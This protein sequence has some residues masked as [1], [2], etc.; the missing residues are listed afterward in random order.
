MNRQGWPFAKV[1][2]TLRPVC[3]G[4][5]GFGEIE[6]HGAVAGPEMRGVHEL[7]SSTSG[8]NPFSGGSPGYGRVYG[9]TQAPAGDAEGVSEDEVHRSRECIPGKHKYGDVPPETRPTGKAKPG[10]LTDRMFSEFLNLY[11]DLSA[12]SG[13]NAPGAI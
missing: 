12:N 5:I 8:D 11:A 10:G 9:T 13:R 7:A 1:P 3:L 4:A 6:H 2:G